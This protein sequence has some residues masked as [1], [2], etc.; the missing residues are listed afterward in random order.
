MILNVNIIDY[1]Q[2]FTFYKPQQILKS[3]SI[4]WIYS[5]RCHNNDGPILKFHVGHFL[6][7]NNLFTWRCICD[8]K[9]KLTSY[10]V[11]CSKQ[12]I[13]M[14]YDFDSHDSHIR[15]VWKSKH[16]LLLKCFNIKKYQLLHCWNF[17]LYGLW[18]AA[19]LHSCKI[20]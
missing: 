19:S 4:Q 20:L 18:K 16:P 17:E 8:W 1:Y 10:Q 3:N 12:S 14:S 9:G 15:N 7:T 11:S 13:F 5:I 6:D 2:N